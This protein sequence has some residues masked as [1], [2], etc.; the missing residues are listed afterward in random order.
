MSF[1]LALM[2]DYDLD[3]LRF[4]FWGKGGIEIMGFEILV[5][6]LYGIGVLGLTFWFIFFCF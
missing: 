5:L 2:F 1:A 3:K 6:R 4:F